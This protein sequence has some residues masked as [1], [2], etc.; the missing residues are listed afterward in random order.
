MFLN[1][2]NQIF[3]REG[4]TSKSAFLHAVA[5]LGSLESTNRAFLAGLDR[6]L[7]ETEFCLVLW[8]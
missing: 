1:E 2:A 3:I 7:L 4:T 5:H 6:E 8:S